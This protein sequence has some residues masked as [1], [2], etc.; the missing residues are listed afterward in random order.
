M[1]L[2]GIIGYPLAHSFS[3]KY[4]TE[5]FEKNNLTDCKY[6]VFPLRSI[7][8]FP[9]LINSQPELKGLSVTI[10]HKKNVLAYLDD[11]SGIPEGMNACNSI[12]ISEGK[13][14]GYNTDVTGFQQSLQPLLKSFHDQALILGNGG[15][16]SAVKSALTNLG[17]RFKIV[18]RTLHD[19]SDLTYEQLNESDISKNLLII[20]CTP[21]GMTP[22]TDAFPPIPYEALTQ[23]HLLFDLIYN[24]AKTK[25]LEK[26]E[27]KGAMIKN[28][29]EMLV[30]QAEASWKIW[31]SD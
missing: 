10:P 18:S 19:D 5:K 4:F 3:K 29:E 12:R 27:A 24:P 6:E 31:N 13:L 28:G 20:N 16:S 22:E 30:L 9:A 2:Y 11:V 8:E 26:G 21:L 17:I 7:T 1:R 25:F 14:F 23:R 15:A